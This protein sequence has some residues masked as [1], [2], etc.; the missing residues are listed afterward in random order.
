MDVAIELAE[1]R[2]RQGWA[3]LRAEL[4]PNGT[5]AEHAADIETFLAEI[6]AGRAQVA[7]I[8]LDRGTAIGFA[9]AS[10][11][12]DY[13]NGCKTSPVA[14]LEGIYVRASHRR[15]GIGKRLLSAIED[16]G[17]GQGCTEMGSDADLANT[18]SHDFHAGMGFSETQRVVFFRKPL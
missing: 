1:A 6:P 7:F 18:Q 3:E 9:E 17:R 10:L 2:H 13:V 12:H 15:S 5:A 16:W 11:R 4:W 14:F 8:A